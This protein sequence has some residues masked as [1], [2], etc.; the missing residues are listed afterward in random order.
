MVDSIL[1]DNAAFYSDDRVSSSDISIND[2]ITSDNILSNKSGVVHSVIPPKGTLIAYKRGDVLV[3][4]IRPYLKKI[5]FANKDGGSSPDVLVIRAKRDYDPAFIYYALFR[6]DF[7]HHMMKGSK[8]TKMPRGDKSQILRFHIPN[9]EYDHQK[10]IS[11]LLSVLDSKIS[12]NNRINAELEAM[13]K[14]IYDY[15][16]VQFDFPM[17]KEQ[18]KQI[19]KPAAAGKPYK[20]SGGKMVYNE[21]LKREI[22]EGWGI[23]SANDLFVFNPS[24]SLKNGT[25]AGYLDMDALPEQGYMTKQIQLKR[26]NGG[27]KFQNGDVAIARITPC[28]ENGKT[29]LITFLKNKE[30]VGFGST[31]FVI[32]RGKNQPL[33]SFAS[34]FSRSELFRKYAIANMTGTSG[35][36]RVDAKMLEIFPMSIP[37]SSLL[38]EFERMINPFFRFTT[39]NQQQNWKFSALRDWLL[40]ML[41]NGQVKI[42]DVEELSMAAE[43]EADYKKAK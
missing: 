12:L 42:R 14:L 21:Q 18:A 24:L 27:T 8:G 23:G 31:E 33:C 3:G 43:G 26:Y 6:D 19:G 40:P 16:F 17:S 28:L 29:A 37:P 38:E 20:T 7:F 32:I 36:K 11:Y 9:F 2:F 10:R 13:A 22:P 5:W 25:V 4:N 1:L 30:E 39:K 15:W 41:M 34:L 35:R